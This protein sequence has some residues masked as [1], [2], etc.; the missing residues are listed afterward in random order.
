MENIITQ[1][2]GDLCR[3]RKGQKQQR[4]SRTNT[5]KIERPYKQ[6]ETKCDPKKST[7]SAKRQPRKAYT[8]G[9]QRTIA[10]SN[11]VPH[12]EKSDTEKIEKVRIFEILLTP[13][14]PLPLRKNKIQQDALLAQIKQNADITLDEFEIRDGHIYLLGR[15]RLPVNDLKNAVHTA[16]KKA[17]IPCYK[18]QIKLKIRKRQLHYDYKNPMYNPRPF[19]VELERM[20]K[21]YT[22]TSY[23]S[24]R[25]AYENKANR[26]VSLLKKNGRIPK[27]DVVI[28]FQIPY[29]DKTL[30][31]TLNE[32][33]KQIEK[34]GLICFSVPEPT[35]DGFGNITDRVH[36]HNLVDS[37]RASDEVKAVIAHELRKLGFFPGENVTIRIA[38]VNDK[39]YFEYVLK[40]GDHHRDKAVLFQKG[41][42]LKKI[43][44][45][46]NWYKTPKGQM[47]EESKQQC[48]TFFEDKYQKEFDQYKRAVESEMQNLLQINRREIICKMSE[49]DLRLAQ[50]KEQQQNCKILPELCNRKTVYYKLGDWLRTKIRLLK[51]NN[52][53]KDKRL[54]YDLQDRLLRMPNAREQPFNAHTIQRE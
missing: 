31:E 12:K 23:T 28:G 17:E 2:V 44:Y 42:K 1:N 9:T 3:R 13:I 52:D 6:T 20:A 14:T 47:R 41:L 54:L 51:L 8:P 39:H 38:H 27:W 45:T 26:E 34:K 30:N 25:A 40:C 32:F 4:T 50:L 49:I 43:Y 29:T 19:L 10:K 53:P 33:V 24:S 21:N 48:K 37:N 46:R 16:A 7:P 35:A 5:A 11:F 36:V 22:P 15:S 18:K